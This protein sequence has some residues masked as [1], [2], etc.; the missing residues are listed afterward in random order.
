MDTDVV[1]NDQ[2]TIVLFTPMTDTAKQWISEHIPDDAQW[3][4][5][6]LVVEHRYADDI[7]VGM[8]SDGLVVEALG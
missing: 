4:G 7:A 8:E 3:F 1:V 5:R 6:S 2:G